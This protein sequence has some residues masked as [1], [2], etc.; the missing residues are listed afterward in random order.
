MNASA[1]HI[2]KNLS[3]LYAEDNLQTLTNTTKTLSLFVKEVLT[4]ENGAD[5]LEIFFKKPVQIVIL[6]YIMPIIDGNSVARQ[7]RLLNKEIPIVIMSSHTE[8]EKLLTC[9]SIGLISYIEKPATLEILIQTLEECALAIQNSGKLQMQ[10]CE[11]AVYDYAKK[12]IITAQKCERLTK[13]E[14]RFL[15]ML[16]SRPMSLL[17]KNEIEEQLFEGE[18]DPN[19][20]RNMVYRLRKKIP[21]NVI[22][23]IK[24]LGYMLNQK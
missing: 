14:Y 6:D 8:K 15:E 17:N 22:I 21:H 11:G 9:M 18:V 12:E 24:D 16:L 5:A 10:I 1:K 4:A 2:L 13:A 20:L 7:I 3:I 19:T 23:T